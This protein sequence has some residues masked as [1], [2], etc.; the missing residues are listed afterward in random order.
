MPPQLHSIEV[1][2]LQLGP[3]GRHALPN[4]CPGVRLAGSTFAGN[5]LSCI[6][7]TAQKEF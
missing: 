1:K 6:S 3:Q 4:Y 2:T 5:C 7:F